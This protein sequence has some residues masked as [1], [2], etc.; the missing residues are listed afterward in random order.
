MKKIA[1]VFPILLIFAF[2]GC[3][4]VE[5]L[6]KNE[7]LDCLEC[8][9]NYEAVIDSLFEETG[10]NLYELSD[11]E[12]VDKIV[13]NH[14]QYAYGEINSKSDVTLEILTQ[15]QNIANQIDAAYYNGDSTGVL[16]L[17]DSLC[18]LCLSINGFI[19]NTN[20]YGF[21]EVVYDMEQAPIYLPIGQMHSFRDDVLSLEPEFC[22]AYP[23]Y[24]DLSSSTKSK[25]SQA[26]L[27]IRAQ[28]L[29][30][31]D[32]SVA[33]CEKEAK[34][35]LVWKI[36]GYTAIYIAAAAACSG[37]FIGVLACEAAAYAGYISRVASARY[38]YVL[39]MERCAN[40]NN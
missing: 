2:I 6:E 30:N 26:A 18:Q 16:L 15:I 31:K 5:L 21:Q 14:L 13:K 8:N 10:I 29:T 4:K 23:Q 7:D 11:L 39:E 35:K 38:T 17:Y 32:F 34:N 36:T 33:D 40:Y 9:N 28:N 3:E 22:L 20:E 24:K 19:F 27:Y 25:I 37:T 1:L 12:V